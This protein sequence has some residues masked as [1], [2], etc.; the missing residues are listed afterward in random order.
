MEH[1]QIIGMLCLQF[2]HFVVKISKCE[3]L[4]VYQNKFYGV[5]LQYIYFCIKKLE[6]YRKNEEQQTPFK[7]M[8]Y[9]FRECSVS[10][11]E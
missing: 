9:L 3:N 7:N 4:R 6:C 11:S 10:F 2:E 1:V 8:H 5:Y